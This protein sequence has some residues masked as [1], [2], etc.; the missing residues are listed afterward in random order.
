M[1]R[2]FSVGVD[3]RLSGGT[4]SFVQPLRGNVSIRGK[5]CC[6]FLLLLFLDCQ[7]DPW[8]ECLESRSMGG[9]LLNKL[10]T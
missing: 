7:I 10:P 1:A 8:G 3:F 5:P 6:M 9:M 4:F 2:K